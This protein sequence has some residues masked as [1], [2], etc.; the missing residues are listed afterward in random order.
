MYRWKSLFGTL[1]LVMLSLIGA[2]VVARA[3]QYDLLIRGGR[4]IDPKNGIDG[5]RDI[6]I[7]QGKVARVAEH[8]PDS[9]AKRVIDATGMIVTPGLIDIHAHVFYGADP[10][11]DYSGG[12]NAVA[13]DGFTFRVGS[14]TT[15]SGRG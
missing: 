9:D 15:A 3:Q 5:L 4:L 12:A 8:L 2:P 14:M 6:A 13:P 7:R 1:V 11:S 10:A